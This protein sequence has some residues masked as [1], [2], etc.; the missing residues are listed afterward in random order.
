MHLSPVPTNH[1][2]FSAKRLLRDRSEFGDFV[3]VRARLTVLNLEGPLA[4]ET[5]RQSH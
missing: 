1:I 5:Y 2:Y 4:L 3:A